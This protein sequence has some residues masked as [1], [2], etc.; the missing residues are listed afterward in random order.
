M[1]I[2]FAPH[3]G[4]AST[5]YLFIDAKANYK[6][7]KEWTLSAGVNNIGNYKAVAFHN[8]P[9]RM[10]FLGLNYDYAGETPRA[11]SDLNLIP[12]G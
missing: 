8:L 3:S 2:S 1:T 6:L 5:G 12:G 7:S 4:S 9:H 11:F 10:Y